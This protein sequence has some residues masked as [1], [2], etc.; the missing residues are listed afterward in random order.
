MTH[1]L[2]VAPGRDVVARWCDLAEQRLEYL[3]ELFET[4]RW[5][6]YH[7]ELA[8]LENIQEA[9]SAVEIWRDL[10]TREASPDN[11]AVDMSWLGHTQTALP[12]VG[13][14]RDQLDRDPPP[15]LQVAA[16]PPPPDA[17][18]SAEPVHVASDEAPS[19]PEMDAPTL[20]DVSEP[21]LDEIAQRYPLLRNAL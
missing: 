21:T 7:S 11:S 20:D 13:R 16:E 14:R 1:R 4:G 2:D 6:R 10:S 15:P 3:T 12:R 8:F 9:K 17:L 5:R 18:M 19:A